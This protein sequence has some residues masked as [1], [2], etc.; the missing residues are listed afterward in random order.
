MTLTEKE[1][2]EAVELEF[3]KYKYIKNITFEDL[4]INLVKALIEK[5]KE[6]EQS[7]KRT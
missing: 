5:I 7:Q 6:N 3:N 4:K 2:I 1:I